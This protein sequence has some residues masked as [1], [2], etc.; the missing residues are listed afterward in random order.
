MGSLEQGARNAVTVCMGV[1]PGER[2]VLVT[3]RLVPTVGDALERAARNV[4]P[5]VTRVTL[6]DLGPRPLTTLPEALSKAASEADVTFWATQSV[7]G[8]LPMRMA[9]RRLVQQRARHGHMPGVTPLLMETGMCANYDEVA[10]LTLR[11]HKFVQGKRTARVTNPVGTDFTVE[12]NPEWRWLADTG[13]FHT[14]KTWGNL[15]AGETYTAPFRL[16]GRIVTHLL[17]DHFSE[18]YGELKTPL[19]FEVRDSWIDMDSFRG[20][21]PEIVREFKEYLLSDPNGPRAAEFACGT[22]TGLTRLVGNLLQDE[23][24]PGVHVAFGHPYSDLTGAPWTANTHVDVVILKTD[25][26]FD[27]IQVQREGQYLMQNLR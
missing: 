14:P 26:W 8:E 27:G 7:K 10:D 16:H 18:K 2:V 25:V 17:G 6:E 12:F 9:F 22:N 13:K 24:I 1:K 11:L 20:A 3:D 19:S 15:P 21:T 23:K 4:T 5:H